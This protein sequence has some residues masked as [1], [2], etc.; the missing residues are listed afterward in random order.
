MEIDVPF[1][2]L[3]PL[4]VL[5]YCVIQ[6]NFIDRELANVFLYKSMNSFDDFRLQAEEVSGI[7]R[8]KFNDFSELWVRWNRNNWNQGIC[9]Q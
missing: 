5:D 3:V 2:E 7:V 8:A 4:G 9:N 6:E 1:D